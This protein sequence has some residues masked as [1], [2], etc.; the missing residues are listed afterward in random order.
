M[1]FKESFR[2]ES[3]HRAVTFHDVT[4]KVKE[5]AARSG[6]KDGIVVVYSH[7]T[8]CSVITQEC[9]FDTSMTGLETLQQDLVNVFENWIPTCRYEGMYLHPGKKAL[10]FAESVG[11]DNF[12]CHNTDAHL[13]SSIIG[14]NVTIVTVDGEMDLGEFGRIHFIDWDQTRGRTRTVQVMI[15]GE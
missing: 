3:N 4:D 15:L 13:R 2:V 14:R 12:G 10:D 7:H 8:T 1:V 6:I 5:I 11:E 9:A